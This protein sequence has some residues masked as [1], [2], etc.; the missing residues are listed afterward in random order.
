MALW[1]DKFIYAGSYRLHDFQAQPY[2]FRINLLCWSY[3][4]LLGEVALGFRHVEI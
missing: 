4:A 3:R 1:I 2:A